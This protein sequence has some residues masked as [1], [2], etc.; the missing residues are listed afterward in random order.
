MLDRRSFMCGAAATL[1]APNIAQAQPSAKVA[2]VGVLTIARSG[3]PQ[4][5]NNFDALREGLRERGWVEGRNI[6]FDYRWADGRYER[7]PILAADLI[8]HK[9]DL[10]VGAT[11]PLIQAAQKV[12]TTVPIVMVGILDPVGAGL[13]TSLARPG[14]NITGLA[15][16][17]GPEIIGK[18]LELLKEMAPSMGRVA[19][20]MNPANPAH[21]PLVNEAETAAYVLR[22]RAKSFRAVVSADLD[23]AFTDML[24]EGIDGLLVVADAVFFSVRE[25][26]AEFAARG[27][28][29]AIYSHREHAVAGGLIAYGPNIAEQWSQAAFFVDRIL[30]GAKPGQLPVEQPTKFELVINLKTAKAL[31]LTIPPSLLARADQVIE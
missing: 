1:S 2:R 20:L 27:R 10:L 5:Q 9:A 3:T 21:G 12:T 17:P 16:L 6:A 26:L 15:F 13:V 11:P 25:Q 7:L 28:L 18:Q 22:M 14:K 24:T 31:G 30:K 4:V 29:P 8:Q 23:T 19:L